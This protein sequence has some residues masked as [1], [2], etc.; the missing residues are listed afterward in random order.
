MSTREIYNESQRFGF[1]VE[2]DGYF[3]PKILR[4]IFEAGEQA[5]VSLLLGWNSAE[6]PTMGLMQGQLLT[7]DNY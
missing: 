1:S 3:L 7:V 6:I 4:E 2:I 5:Q